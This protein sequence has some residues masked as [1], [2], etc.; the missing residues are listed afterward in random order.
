MQL[1]SPEAATQFNLK[2]KHL[3][4]LTGAKILCVHQ[5]SF[6]FYTE[7]AQPYYHYFLPLF[8]FLY[9]YVY[10]HV[11]LSPSLSINSHER[12]GSTV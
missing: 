9:V 11:Y 3:G 8:L 12:H 7:N 4:L 5:A 10:L 2:M 6:C 1:C